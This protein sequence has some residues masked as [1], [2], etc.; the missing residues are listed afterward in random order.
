MIVQRLVQHL[1]AKE[2]AIG[3]VVKGYERDGKRLINN[4][5]QGHK[6]EYERYLVH[7]RKAG[8]KLVSSFKDVQ[9][10]LTEARKEIKN[11]P[12]QDLAKRMRTEQ[13]SLQSRLE[14]AI[15]ACT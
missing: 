4:L 12:I 5:A 7:T 1:I 9:K 8:E 13:Q 10:G 14:E 2:E 11:N 6:D 15:L 3:D